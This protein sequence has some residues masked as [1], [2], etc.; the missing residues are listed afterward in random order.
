MLHATL[1]GH[2]WQPERLVSPEF[3]ELGPLILSIQG[4]QR[5]G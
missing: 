1:A 3:A 4:G 5:H 2:S